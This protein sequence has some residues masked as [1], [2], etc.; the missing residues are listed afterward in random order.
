MNIGNDSVTV[1]LTTDLD[2]VITV[3]VEKGG[4]DAEQLVSLQA[5]LDRG[6][7]VI[8]F[9][10]HDLGSLASFPLYWTMPWERDEPTPL[11]APDTKACGLGWRYLPA[12]RVTA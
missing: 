6:D 10:N 2:A 4:Y 7:D 12:M 5:W 1:V 11:H 8:V 3:M 9:S